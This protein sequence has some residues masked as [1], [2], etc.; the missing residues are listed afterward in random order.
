MLG[1]DYRVCAYNRAGIDGSSPGPMPRDAVAIVSDLEKLIRQAE[2]R[3]PF[4]LVGH[5]LGGLTVRLFA[6]RNLAAVA[7]IVLVD[8]SSEDMLERMA[9]ISS[10]W[11]DV[12][13][14]DRDHFQRCAAEPNGH[15]C[16]LPVPD[17]APPALRNK[18]IAQLPEEWFRAT[19]SELDSLLRADG[20]S[21]QIKAAGADVGAIPMVVL[22]AD[23]IPRGLPESQRP[24][25]VA[26]KIAMHK[27]IAGHSRRG[28]HKLITGTSHNMQ[29]DRPDA[30]VEAVKQI[31]S[32]VPRSQ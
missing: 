30:V 22:T 20:D 14:K 31:A 7:G 23:S 10:E 9:P 25:L 16:K 3:P 5:S 32:M 21:A 1:R 8:P 6:R 2:L 18:L 26:A 17:D 11:V 24:A 27:I 12:L 15:D 13:R 28:V 4:I 29:L 19:A